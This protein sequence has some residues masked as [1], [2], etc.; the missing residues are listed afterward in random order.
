MISLFIINQNK[1]I[2]A[3]VTCRQGWI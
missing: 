3:F 1:Q 2:T